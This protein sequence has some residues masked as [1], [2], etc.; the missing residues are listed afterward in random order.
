MIKIYNITNYALP[1]KQIP[2]SQ[3]FASAEEAL[4]ISQASEETTSKARSQIIG[5]LKKAKPSKPNL[6]VPETKALRELRNNYSIMILPADKGRATVV[7]NKIDYD[8]KV[9]TML[10]DHSTYKPLA[11][12]K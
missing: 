10:A 2:T 4:R 9:K 8:T 5:V 11:K 7:M 6:S 1:P 3:I 12:D